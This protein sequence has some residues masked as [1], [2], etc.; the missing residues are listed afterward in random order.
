MMKL[1]SSISS[2]LM[3]LPNLKEMENDVFHVIVEQQSA[4]GNRFEKCPIKL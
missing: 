3:S 2:P 4:D 1:L